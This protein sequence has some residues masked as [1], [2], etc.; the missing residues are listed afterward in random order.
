METER[1]GHLPTFNINNYHKHDGSLGHKVYHKPTQTNL[2]LNSSSHHHPS[3]KQAVLSML[4]HRARS[5]CDWESLHAELEFLRD[6]FWQNS[7]S[8][9]QIPQVL[10]PPEIHISPRETCLSH[11]PALLSMT[12]NRIS[13]LLSRQNR[14]RFPVSFS[15]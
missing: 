7:Y 10:N 12:F 4:M 8:N 11:L 2:Y 9:W 13:R 6:T 5:L 3:I 14:G 15:L 1:D